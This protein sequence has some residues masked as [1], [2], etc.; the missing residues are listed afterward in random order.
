MKIIK[1]KEQAINEKRLSQAEYHLTHKDCDKCPCCGE[2]TN[3]TTSTFEVRKGFFNEKKGF[4]DRYTC[5]TCGAIWESG[6]YGFY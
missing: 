1:T 2:E 6:A 4:K 5:Q 3:F